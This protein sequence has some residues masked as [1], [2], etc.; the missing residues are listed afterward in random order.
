MTSIS[1]ITEIPHQLEG[2][3]CIPLQPRN[4]QPI[5]GWNFKGDEGKTYKIRGGEPLSADKRC[6]VLMGNSGL[7]VADCEV[8]GR[9]HPGVT[10]KGEETLLKIAAEAGVEVPPTFTVISQSG[11]KHFYFRQ[12]PAC[13]LRSKPLLNMD[14]KA[15][16]NT[17]CAIGGGYLILDDSP[18]ADIPLEL[19]RAFLAQKAVTGT[20][21]TAGEAG[22]GGSAS[23]SLEDIKP[24]DLVAG[25]QRTYYLARMKGR[26]EKQGYTEEKAN[27]M[28]IDLNVKL[29]DPVDPAELQARVLAHKE[30]GHWRH[31]YVASEEE[32]ESEEDIVAVSAWIDSLE[33]PVTSTHWKNI[34][35]I[36][37]GVPKI[38]KDA[39]DIL[40]RSDLKV[41]ELMER[42][43]RSNLT[44]I[45]KDKQWRLW[46][47]KAHSARE[48]SAAA[49][50]VISFAEGYRLAIESIKERFIA[51]QINRTGCDWIDAY[52][53]YKKVWGAHRSYRDGLMNDPVQTRVLRQLK[54]RENIAVPVDYFAGTK[55]S[56]YLLNFSN[57][58]YDV[59]TG[60]IR[61]HD[62]ADRIT[63]IITRSLNIAL[64]DK[65]LQDAAPQFW[66]LLCRMCG[67]PGEVSETR[68]RQRVNAVWRWCAYQC[69]GSNPEKKMAIFEGASNI[70]KNQ[71]EEILAEL[72]GP[73][74]AHTSASSKLL[75]K[76]RNDRHDSISNVLIGRRMVVVN[77][78]SESQVLDDQQVLVLV[79]PEGTIVDL[80]HLHHDS[81]A[82]AVTW[83]ITVT[84]NQLARADLT[85][86][87]TNR[88]L[89]LPL[90]DV[91]VPK[92]EQYDIKR[93]IMDHEADAVLAHL[94]KE[95]SIWHKTWKDESTGL[96]NPPD[97]IER[98]NRYKDENEHPAQQ[99][100]A[101]R[102]RLV[103]HGNVTHTSIWRMCEA[104]YK[105]QHSDL[106][107]R[108]TGG[109]RKLF[110]IL[111]EIEVVERDL[112]PNGRLKGFRG[113]EVLP[114]ENGSKEQ[115]LVWD[116]WTGT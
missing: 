24:L 8:P 30:W 91:E 53:E 63:T 58:T 38:K 74:L 56:P 78:L 75:V 61:P 5:P 26:Y 52:E 71:L 31:D 29:G 60:A 86:Q 79:N 95:W 4:K 11:G 113:I 100:I 69:H 35:K 73:D 108:Y 7:L 89:I 94:V 106:P 20:R 76:T 65:P 80:R 48:E 77:E 43:Y 42:Y 37:S 34:L 111:D 92:E 10:G 88:L 41:A 109:R 114:P 14:L 21:K 46:N 101:E 3:L 64:A 66:S 40:P 116:S 18:V 103:S 45:E 12:H 96:I 28:I 83:K 82:A 23:D 99:F 102:C 57:G 93:E 16:V 67:A 9:D 97:A 50:L 104:Y 54:K 25:D 62:R 17:Y 84:T 98:L 85:P 55:D 81:V 51:D 110:A 36:S 107:S 49:S 22:F 27:E 90:S 13:P 59:R 115:M 47:T 32:T 33:I 6:G 2:A 105:D 68:H 1:F 70:G 19:A 44:Y 87:I 112:Q 39:R 72:L 15:S